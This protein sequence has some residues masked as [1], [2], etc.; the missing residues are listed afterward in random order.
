[1]ATCT[2]VYRLWQPAPLCVAYGNLH[3]LW[4]PTPLTHSP[5][6]LCVTNGWLE[7]I[8]HMWRLGNLLIEV[9]EEDLG[10]EILM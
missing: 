8:E 10:S 9:E 4:Q 3:H 7:K 6:K 5:A 2:T 1:M